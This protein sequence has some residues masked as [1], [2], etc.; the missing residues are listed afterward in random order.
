LESFAFE[1]FPGRPPHNG[2]LWGNSAFVVALLLGQSFSEAG[3]EMRAG[4]LSQI[5]NLPLHAFRVE[6]DTQ[7]KPCAE[8]LLTEEAVEGILDHGLIP[9][10]SYKGRDSVRV[11][12]FQSMADPHRPLA[13]RWQA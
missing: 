2:Y 11:G 8:V 3:W 4:S 9:M 12:R 1:E 13:G 7:L 6:G 5:E 10:V